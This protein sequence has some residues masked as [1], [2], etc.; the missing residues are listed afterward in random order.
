MSAGRVCVVGSLSMHTTVRVR[1]LPRPGESV[2]GIG[3]SRGP[4]GKGALQAVAAARAGAQ[5]SIIGR[6]GR[7]DDG[8]LIRSTLRREPIH[9]VGLAESW[10]EPTGSTFVLVDQRGENAA[11]VVPGANGQLEPGDLEEARHT[12]EEA[13]VVL[14]TFEL[15]ES[16]VTRAAQLAKASGAR[17]VLNVAPARTIEPG[18]AALV[19]L[20]VVNLH[21]A[22]VL[23]GVEDDAD[24]RELETRLTGLGAG[25]VLVTRGGAGSVLLSGSQRTDVTVHD[26]QVVDTSG[27]G[28][29]AIGALA[30]DW[31]GGVPEGA[32]PL[33]EDLPRAV[34]FAAAA[35]SVAVTRSRVLESAPM[36]DEIDEMLRRG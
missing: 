2:N 32:T 36:R 27:A 12:I 23:A 35:G 29:V 17:V 22:R 6:V 4:G 21:E 28:D 13:S 18:L 20:I 24:D 31:A 26:V 25:A 11:V 9:T 15:P 3:A 10:D 34:R 8:A 7:D 30:A 14:V 19:D 33:M 5:V 1:R 16:T